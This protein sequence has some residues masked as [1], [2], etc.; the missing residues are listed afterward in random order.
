MHGSL[1]LIFLL[2]GMG[3]RAAASVKFS[4]ALARAGGDLAAVRSG[5]I[6]LLPPQS[7]HKKRKISSTRVSA[8][9]AAA[10]LL[11]GPITHAH[12]HG[13]AAAPP[14]APEAM[15]RDISYG[16]PIGMDM[17]NKAIIAAAEEAKARTAT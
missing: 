15:P 5:R 12:A 9:F 13:P 2:V 17:T 6:R 1:L 16:N 3:T 14:P 11:N 8:A 4:T 10:L 7:G